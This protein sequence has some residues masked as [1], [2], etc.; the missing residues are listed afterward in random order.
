MCKEY[1]YSTKVDKPGAWETEVKIMTLS[2][3]VNTPILVYMQE[4]C[5]WTVST[6]D[7]KIQLEGDMH[8]KSERVALVKSSP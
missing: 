2:Y 8:L 3:L 4:L 7:L 5:M 6:P 1:I